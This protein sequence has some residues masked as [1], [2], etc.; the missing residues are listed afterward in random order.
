MV[1]VEG[2]VEFR[3]I[4]QPAGVVDTDPIAGLGGIAISLGAIGVLR[5]EGVVTALSFSSSSWDTVNPFC[6]EFSTQA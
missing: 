5:P 2:A 4:G 6:S 3:S 1:T